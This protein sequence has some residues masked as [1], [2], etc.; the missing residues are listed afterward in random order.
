[1]GV[2]H[3][4]RRATVPAF[5]STPMRRPP[6]RPRPHREQRRGQPISA[7]VAPG[8]M[9][10]ACQRSCSLSPGS[11]GHEPVA[12]QFVLAKREGVARGSS[13]AITPCGSARRSCRP[14]VG[15]LTID[16]DRV[17]SQAT[18]ATCSGHWGWTIAGLAVRP[19]VRLAASSAR[20]GPVERSTPAGLVERRHLQAHS[21]APARPAA[22]WK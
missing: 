22:G 4:L 15:E 13:A 11:V 3:G 20:V 6:G 2:D 10:A 7:T 1:M 12:P 21:P 8:V 19:I 9:P 16:S 18:A 5:P 17:A 14:H